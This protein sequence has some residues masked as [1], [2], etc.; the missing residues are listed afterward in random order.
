M[1]TTRPDGAQDGEPSGARVPPTILGEGKATTIARERPA[2]DGA[3]TGGDADAWLPLAALP[4][5]SGW[6]L[7][8][9]GLCRDEFC[10]PVSPQQAATLLREAGGETWLDL[11]AFAR[12]VGLP[13]ARDRRRNIWS[14]G[15]PAYERQGYGGTGPAPDFTLP[16]F[17]GR[18]RSLSDFRGTKVFLV[19][20]SSW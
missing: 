15:P 5:A 2:P 19:T 1:A 3:G 18:P 8:P 9:E 16:D 13:Y 4:E 14:F 6:E 11:T 20:W 12:H 7:K 17:D 10:V